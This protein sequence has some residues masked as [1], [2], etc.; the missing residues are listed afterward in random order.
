MF[1][2]KD[3][4]ELSNQYAQ[5]EKPKKK[6]PVKNIII[7]VIVL[8]I[9]IGVLSQ[10]GGNS[11]KSTSFSPSSS[12]VSTAAAV[13]SS[14]AISSSKSTSLQ[15]YSAT[16]GAGNYTV[17]IDIPAGKYNLT[18]QSGYGNVSSSNMYDGGLNEVMGTEQSAQKTFTGAKFDKDVTLSISGSLTL[19]ISSDA[20]DVQN[21]AAR[22]NTATKEYTF[23]SGNYTC[24]TDFEPGEYVITAASG[25][26]NVNSD[27]MYD[28]GLNEVMGTTNG[29]LSQFSNAEFK[30][31]TQLQ[32]SGGV[33]IKMSPSK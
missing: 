29:G 27:N 18:A 10:C 30:N 7:G 24:G 6:L 23:S 5:P 1:G 28:G 17:G 11:G 4:Q 19:Q 12:S 15:S 3:N 25:Y 20:A 16:L 33:T 22:K 32:I 26:G 9:L 13:T 2:K 31:G 21:L 8:F 14:K